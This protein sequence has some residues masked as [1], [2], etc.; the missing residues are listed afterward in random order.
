M[1]DGGDDRVRMALMHASTR[2][3]VSEM[4]ARCFDTFLGSEVS[5]EKSR[6]WVAFLAG[7]QQSEYPAITGAL[8]GEILER[9]RELR[10]RRRGDAL[11]EGRS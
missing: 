6:D 5:V 4:L 9:E 3:L 7:I 10:E 11:P 1:T 2:G 8:L